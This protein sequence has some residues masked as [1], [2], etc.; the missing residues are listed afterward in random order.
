MRGFFSLDGGLF[1]FFSK[2]FDILFVSFLFITFSIPLVTMGPAVTAMYYTTVKVIRKE[3]GYIFA[4]FWKCFKS[5]FLQGL[6]YSVIIIVLVALFSF[7][8]AYAMDM[9]GNLGKILICIYAVVC[10]L[11]FSV[12]VYI[13]PVLSRFSMKTWEMIK[14][15]LFISMRHFPT[16]LL[17]QVIIIAIG[18]ILYAIPIASFFIPTLGTLLYSFVIEKILKKYLPK[19]DED[20]DPEKLEWYYNV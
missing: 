19:V 7:N 5:N 2:I 11:L 1:S 20:I 16:T 9:Q 4:E 13:F 8:I 18:L 6:I 14:F 12:F 17:L 15:T 3:H 10:Y